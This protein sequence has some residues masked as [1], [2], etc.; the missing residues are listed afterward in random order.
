MEDY[1]QKTVESYDKHAKEFA[2]KFKAKMELNRRYEFPRFIELLQGKDMLDLGCGA[3]DH[4][5]YFSQQGL[6]VTCIDLSEE[7]IKLCRQKGLD[8]AFVMDIENL[9]FENN[10]FDGIWATASLLH[11]P[12][13]KIEDVVQSLHGLLRNN[14]VLYVCVKEGE[15]ER[16]MDDKHY[17]GTK[18]FFAFWTQE[19]LLNMFGK[20]FTVIE[21]KKDKLGHT[22]FLEAFFRKK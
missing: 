8:K 15:G 21:S 13:A 17:E 6:N 12:K 5:V 7:M 14:G 9:A 2:E 4:S 18:R 3:G 11:V 19:E 20:Q 10:S 16:L 1:K 22:S